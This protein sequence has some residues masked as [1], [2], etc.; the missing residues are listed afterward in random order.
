MVKDIV[1]ETRSASWFW[2]GFL[3]I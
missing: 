1:A 2:W 3:I